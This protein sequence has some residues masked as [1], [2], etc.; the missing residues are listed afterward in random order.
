MQVFE[1]HNGVLWTHCYQTRR[2][3]GTFDIFR[4]VR[5]K[6]RRATRQRLSIEIRVILTKT[7]MWIRVPGVILYRSR[8]AHCY[9][10]MLI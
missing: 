4:R 10:D 7:P 6:P 3:K 9:Y 2:T 5:I 1:V 8:C